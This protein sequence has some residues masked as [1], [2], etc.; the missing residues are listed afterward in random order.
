[1]NENHAGY[2]DLHF[3]HQFIPETYSEQAP[4]CGDLMHELFKEPRAQSRKKASKEMTL[5]LRGVLGMGTKLQ[6]LRGFRG[7]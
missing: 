1:M 5:V 3:Y 4:C 2:L 7:H 6:I